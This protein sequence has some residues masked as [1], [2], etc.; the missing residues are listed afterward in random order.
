MKNIFQYLQNKKGKPIPFEFK[1]LNNIPLKND[2]L[3]YNDHIYLNF[4]KITSLPDNLKVNGHLYLFRTKITS[5][6]DNLKV[7]GSIWCSYTPLADNIKKD[8]SLLK[9]YSKQ[10]KG[11]IIYE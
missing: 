2:E 10:V 1:L 11:R 8:I 4:T 6:P 9:K 3:I 5:L 7:N